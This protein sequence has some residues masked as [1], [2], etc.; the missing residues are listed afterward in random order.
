[1]TVV[2]SRLTFSFRAG[3]GTCR[4]DYCSASKAACFYKRGQLYNHQYHLMF[5]REAETHTHTN[6]IHGVLNDR[7][8]IVQFGPAGSAGSLLVS[9]S[10]HAFPDS[11][12]IIFFTFKH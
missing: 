10:S 1:M 12:V 6:P 4:P 7:Q 11:P 9:C 8:V 3:E 2:Y 5:V